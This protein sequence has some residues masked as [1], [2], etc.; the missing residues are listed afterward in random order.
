MAGLIEVEGPD[1]KIYEFPEG[2]SDEAMAQVMR[3]FYPP[4]EQGSPTASTYEELIAKSRELAAAGDMAGAK[5]VAQIAIT[6]RDAASAKVTELT[7]EQQK[8]VALANARR[9]AA[10]AQ[11]YDAMGFPQ[12]PQGGSAT[13]PGA[14]S[15]MVGNIHQAG[16]GTSEGVA[17][18]LGFPV[19]L[20]TMAMNAGSRGINAVAGTEIPQIV[21]PVGGSGMF[22]KALDPFIS[23]EAPK[24]ATQRYL[25]RGG[26]A[27]GFGIPAAMTGAA[28]SPTALSNMPSYMGAST[29]G[30]VTSAVAGQTSRE[31]APNNNTAD[32]IASMI[33]G[34]GG[35]MA[36][37]RLGTKVG[38]AP[39]LD[40]LRSRQSEAYG[41]VDASQA[42][43]SAAERQGLIDQMQGRTT[44][45]EMDEFMHPRANR[46][47]ERMNSLEPAPR[48]ADVEKKRRLVGR[49]VAGSLDPSEAAIG[50][51][52]KDEIDSYLKNL[53]GS[54][55][56]G[57]D[58]SATL[59]H[60]QQGRDFTSRIK[61]AEA[62]TGAVTKAERRA[63]SAGTGGNEINATRQNIRAMLDDPKQSRGFSQPERAQMEGIVR[64][65]P[66][67]NVGRM[68][69]R[70]SPTAGALPMMGNMAAM[71]GGA[72]GEL[73]AL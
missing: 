18:F 73:V 16:S 21:S 5:R 29:A 14:V 7:L 24:N 53:A 4:P 30:D 38:Q 68:F 13:N 52:M 40:D 66:G 70:L 32:L 56:L 31:I 6:R 20:A 72:T 59:S 62:I 43:L 47:M 71:A 60:L 44:A 8:A 33:G 34:V 15:D 9:R 1:G 28:F 65:T 41:A 54:G 64:G 11:H 67:V 46:T 19:D 23:D 10:G 27:L 39:T 69:G 36:A 12:E 55:N 2:T 42:R 51:G 45:M 58:A 35:S 25:R 22:E 3:G 49:D 26:Q 17:N 63:A 57:D 50:Q 48:I 61:K 37:A